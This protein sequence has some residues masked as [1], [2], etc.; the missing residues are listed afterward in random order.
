MRNGPDRETTGV[1]LRKATPADLSDLLK[2]YDDILEWLTERG[3]DQWQASQLEPELMKAAI[4]A[5][6]HQQQTWCAV[7][8]QRPAGLVIIKPRTA[9]GMWTPG[10]EAEPHRYLY[11]ILVSREY[12]GLDLGADLGDWAASRTAAEGIPIIRGDVWTTNGPL[13]DYY[14]RHGWRLVRKIDHSDHPSGVL[15]ERPTVHI[16]IPNLTE[17]PDP[18]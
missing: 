1:L 7:D 18:T 10:E 14:L 15:V 17:I 9:P 11:L 13:V 3:N 12:T 4:V 5:S 6:V 8:G 16:E 2:M